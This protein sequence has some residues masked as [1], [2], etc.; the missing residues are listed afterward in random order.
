MKDSLS[1]FEWLNHSTNP[2]Y[3]VNSDVNEACAVYRCL[4]EQEQLLIRIVIIE[5]TQDIW[6]NL[7]LIGWQLSNFMVLFI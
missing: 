6:F 4:T 7:S 2:K 3:A 1:C 5:V